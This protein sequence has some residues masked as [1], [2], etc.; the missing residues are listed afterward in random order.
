MGAGIVAYAVYIPRNRIS[1]GE[2]RKSWGSFAAPGVKEKAVPA[3]DED[4]ITMAVE[5]GRTLLEKEVVKIEDVNL[6]YLASTSTPYVEKSGAVTVAAALGLSGSFRMA[7][8]GG[9]L[10]AGTAALLAAL[11]WAEANDGYALVVAS[12][13]PRARPD[14]GIEH[15]LGA[16]AIA[17][18]VGKNN[19]V[20]EVDGF[21]G[22]SQ[23]DLG[24]RFR[25]SGEEFIQDLEIRNQTF[26]E[27][28]KA[29]VKGLLDDLGLE[30]KDIAH[31]VV[32]QPNARSPIQAGGKL[33]FDK[34]QLKYSS[35][36]AQIGDTATASVF[37]SMA[38]ALDE[39]DAGQRLV[40]VSC[41]SGSDA[42]SLTVKDDIKKLN[43]VPSVNDLIA[44]KV[45]VDY[46]TYLKIRRYL[47]SQKAF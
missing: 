9:S 41:G 8:F 3:Y 34:E 10:R 31:L 5:A 29:S 38:Q 26:V 47:S 32:Q 30:P 23:D 24:I 33:K 6:I 45:E 17:M 19:V 28:V 35:T 39:A 43:R 15:G 16:G 44:D 13:C 40:I 25:P 27:E 22:F 20:A 7:D 2:Y 14:S 21:F 4:A 36:A 42:V 18:L 46:I 11:D 1:A 37:I 12:D